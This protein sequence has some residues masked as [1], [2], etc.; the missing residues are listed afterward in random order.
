MAMIAFL[1]PNL[2]PVSLLLLGAWL[3]QG[4]RRKFLLGL[5]GMA[6]GAF[7]AVLASSL[8]FG[9]VGIWFEWLEKLFILAEADVPATEGN[10]NLPRFLGLIAGAQ[11]QIALG[12]LVCALPLGFLW[13][14]RKA[15]ELFGEQGVAAGRER[16]LIEYAQLIGMGCLVHL[17]GSS[18]AWLHYYV[19]AIPMLI[20]AFRP[21]SRASAYGALG[22]VLFRLF[23]ALILVAFL[24]GPHWGLIHGDFYAARAIANITSILVLFVLGLW[25][26]KHQ[27]G[28]LPVQGD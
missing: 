18:L 23:P 13:W 15:N 11:G 25:Q 2:A 10:Y 21:W 28:R 5:A 4:Q 22:I 1:K 20:V 16:A 3:I 17:M 19:L 27:D 9:D 24:S 12:L 26:L 14:G 8:F 7:L 6:A